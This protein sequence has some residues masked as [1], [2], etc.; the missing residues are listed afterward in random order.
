MYR[1][2]L[3]YEMGRGVEPDIEKAVKY[4]R[5]AAKGNDGT[6]LQYIPADEGRPVGETRFVKERN[7]Q[8]RHAG[9]MYR[10]GLYYKN[11]N[12]KASDADWSEYWFKRAAKAGYEGEDLTEKEKSEL[13][14][15][16]K[17]QWDDKL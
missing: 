2:G 14:E 13:L 10:L 7:A 5:K 4:Y 6:R 11:R 8:P 16:I 9:A 12:K 15:V 1:V 3:A 17:Y